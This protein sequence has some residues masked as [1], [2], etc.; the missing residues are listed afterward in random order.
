MSQEIELKLS[1]PPKAVPALR[2]HPVF[3]GA[4]RQGNAVTLD[5]TYFDTPDLALKQ[6]KVALRIRRHGRV[7]LQTVKC[8]AV[9]AGGLTQRPE[10]EQSYSGA[11]DFSAIDA[12]KVLKLL[13]RHEAALQPVFST[14]F[15]RETR[16]Y[17]PR[18]GVRILMM[19][20]TGE[21]I[22]GEQR[23][24][25]CELELELVEGEPLDL[26]LLGSELAAHLPLLP[27][28]V[29]KAERGYRLHLGCE[30]EA[31]RAE[32]STIDAKQTP[33]EA[34]RTLAFS[35]LRQWQAN[36]SAAAHS[37]KPEFIHQLRVAL[38]RLRSLL[39]LFAPALP[40]DFVAD[41]RERLK[42]NADRF[43]D[44]RDLDVL[45]DEVL[46]PV[47]A[48][49]TVEEPAVTRLAGLA[50]A[51]R[52]EARDAA[53][54]DLDLAAQGRLLIGLTAALHALPTNDLIEA[55][56][57]RS[58]ARL[59]LTRLRKKVR[60]RFEA[61]A[62]F[63]PAHL[64]ALRIALKRLRYGVEF[65]APLFS[66]KAGRRYLQR[67]VRA[68]DALGFVNDVEVARGRLLGWAGEDAEL[69][70]AA[71]FVSGW[72]SPKYARLARRARRELEPLLWG[73]TPWSR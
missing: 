10:W 14:R 22:A 61:A 38:R 52:D 28:D 70:A 41:W 68:Q 47:V 27:N 33:A 16:L 13:K 23:E 48:G 26:L 46:A 31:M 8:S 66:P 36:A 39:A 49:A 12:P 44:T 64:H 72:H 65:F 11:F 51:A 34:F 63:V 71:A 19:I 3:S 18:E 42:L 17:A 21:V 35:C 30:P 40:A 53:V 5:N 73:K 15:R 50:L 45:Y 20:D 55:I 37:S 9:S 43:G 29:S 54:H 4:A 7:R 1:L 56:D 67:I 32:A 24:P 58:F 6:R 60:R 59:Q 57:L 69:R 2:R 25:I 62:D